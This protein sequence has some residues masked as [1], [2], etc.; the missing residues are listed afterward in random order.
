MESFD[1]NESSLLECALHY[2]KLGFAVFP[3]APGTKVPL[4]GSHGIKDGTTDPKKIR[5]WWRENPLYNIGFAAGNVSGGVVILDLDRNHKPGVDGVESLQEWEKEHGMEIYTRGSTAAAKTPHGGIHVYF[6]HEGIG[7]PAGILPGVDVRGNGGFAVLPPS[8]VK[9]RCYKWITPPDVNI[10]DGE[11]LEEFLE[12]VRP[13]KSGEAFQVPAEISEGVRTQTL[14]SLIFSLRRKGLNEAT[15]RAAIRATNDEQCTPPLSEEELEKEVFPAIKRPLRDSPDFQP[16]ES[17]IRDFKD[18]REETAAVAVRIEEL[19]GGEIFRAKDMD[20]AALFSELFPECR[21]NKTANEWYFYNGSRWGKDEKGMAAAGRAKVFADGVLAYAAGVKG[22]ADVKSAFIKAVTKLLDYPV[23]KRILDDA[24]EVNVI[25]TEELDT[26]P[27]LLNLKNGTLNL[28]TGEFKEHS[29]GDLLSKVARVEYIPGATSPAFL[30][31]FREIME[32][33]EEKMVFTQKALAYSILARPTLETFFICYGPTTRNGKSTLL[34]TILFLLGDYGANV[35]PETF[36]ATKRDPRSASWDVA[37][38][39]GVRFANVSEPKMGLRFDEA[40][41]KSFVANG[42][43]TARNLFESAFEFRPVA[44]LWW[45]CN[46]LP[47]ISDRT[48]FDSDRVH[49]IPFN[50]YFDERERDPELKERLQ[51]PESLAGILNWL[52]EGLKLF[53]ADG[54]RLIAPECVK[55]ATEQYKED[56]D[57]INLFLREETEPASGENIAG[58]ALF[59]RYRV[60]CKDSGF[61]SSGKTTFFRTLRERGLLETSGTVEGKTFHNVIKDRRFT[62]DCYEF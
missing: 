50:R 47:T 5:K 7:S 6:R 12:I 30:K 41:I 34:S 14:I 52:L 4:K 31:F 17:A 10:L 28:K 33:D 44:V 29:P 51:E 59:E 13:K 36:E 53:R 15:V 19:T 46:F 40:L 58:V 56:S 23:R 26:A 27:D 38:L 43:Q 48:I 18:D 8:K 57:K 49:V 45:D 24:R 62:R 3:L 42:V 9:G 60:W 11:A 35:S 21:Y 32:D 20:Y 16:V 39:K 54:S 37:R 2:A 61:L 22:S 25:S 55:A 1:Y